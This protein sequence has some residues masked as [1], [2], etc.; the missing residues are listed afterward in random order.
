MGVTSWTKIEVRD[1]M[2]FIVT[3]LWTNLKARDVS[4]FWD[5]PEFLSA[6][7]LKEMFRQIYLHFLMAD[8]Q[9]WKSNKDFNTDVSKNCEAF[10]ISKSHIK[11]FYVFFITIWIISVIQKLLF[12]FKICKTILISSSVKTV[13][14]RDL[15]KL[16][17]QIFLNPLETSKERW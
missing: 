13:C 11:S 5:W 4:L 2:F 10:Q 6:T 16:L 9:E 8:V 3:Y 14:C 1:D 15:D 17:N 7:L 12:L